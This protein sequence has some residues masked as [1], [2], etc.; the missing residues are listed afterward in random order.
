MELVRNKS[1]YLTLS[2][3]NQDIDL[4]SNEARDLLK[5]YCMFSEQYIPGTRTT[6][7][8]VVNVYEQ[9][10]MSICHDKAF[11]G[12]WQIFALSS[13]LHCRLFSVY[14]DLGSYLYRVTLNRLIPPI[15]NRHDDVLASVVWTSTRNDMTKKN[16]VPHHFVPLIPVSKPVDVEVVDMFEDT[17]V[18]DTTVDSS[19][20]DGIIRN[21]KDSP[22]TSFSEVP[23]AG[24]SS[25]GSVYIMFI[26]T[27]I[28]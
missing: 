6:R 25:D 9:E 26:K 28:F 5:T 3:I 12:I 2:H 18:M 11:M 23:T 19:I 13:L 24:I 21:R 4:N 10:V 16:W 22:D 15:E 1:T 8:T 20:I 14:P 27:G 17:D 7:S